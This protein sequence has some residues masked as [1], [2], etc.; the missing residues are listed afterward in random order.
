MIILVEEKF[1]QRIWKTNIEGKI[2]E[3][4]FLEY[5]ALDGPINGLRM[6]SNA[7]EALERRYCFPYIC[8]RVSLIQ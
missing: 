2:V 8:D 6:F 4:R 7:L 5:T 1:G 3:A